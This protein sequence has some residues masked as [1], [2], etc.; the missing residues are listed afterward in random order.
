MTKVIA[1]ASCYAARQLLPLIFGKPHHGRHTPSP[2]LQ[3]LSWSNGQSMESPLPKQ[4]PRRTLHERP[5]PECSRV[6]RSGRRS[7]QTTLHRMG[8]EDRTGPNPN[9]PERSEINQNELSN[10]DIN[11]SEWQH[12]DGNR[13]N[14]ERSLTK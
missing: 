2:A 14:S 10:T 5:P 13:N 4:T 11:R 12:I 3:S 7:L 6:Q 1:Y 8:E 9:K